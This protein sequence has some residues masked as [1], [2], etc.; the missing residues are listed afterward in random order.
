MT[1]VS[2]RS[3]STKHSKFA[4][5][6]L[7]A[8]LSLCAASPAHAQGAPSAHPTI[9]PI[10]R[11]ELDA[12]RPLL[13]RGP[14]IIPRAVDQHANSHPTIYVRVAAPMAVVHRVVRSA[15]EYRAFVPA[16]GEVELQGSTERRQAFRFRVTAAIFD[17]RAD[18]RVN[19][20]NERRVDV[21]VARSDFGPA[22]TRW[23]F[24]DDGAQG[25][26]AALTVW[27]D[28][29]QA[30]WAI[31]QF[32]NASAYS[33]SSANITVE[34]VLALAVKRRAE[35][36]AGSRQ[37]VR[38]RA[39]TAPVARLEP[40]TPG[41]WLTYTRSGLDVVSIELDA[42]GSMRSV[43]VGRHVASN[44]ETVRARLMEA[45][46]W[47]QYW[48]WLQNVQI[49]EQRSD[50]V[51][52]RSSLGTPL[53]PGRGEIEA[54]LDPSANTVRIQGRNGDFTRDRERWDFAADPQGGT[55]VTYTGVSDEAHAAW[56]HH[57]LMDRDVWAV[58]GLSAYW[59]VV[60]IRYGMWAL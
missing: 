41:E 49:L 17:V 57:I 27:C 16:L 11:A 35:I 7:G 32:A 51:R 4:V 42:Q 6:M 31:R 21:N 33:A 56:F 60:T 28:P 29:S 18:V 20:V 46:Y 44:V 15:E 54:R 9:E 25:T 38:P 39:A 10:E 19:V 34:T 37:P 5:G 3:N 53:S 23:E 40:P 55:F 36:L 14:V 47:S 30:T 1:T 8:A 45:Q 22:G 24:F 13:A 52:I 43:S 58:A 2:K 12:I 26:I 48:L 59:K 50:Y